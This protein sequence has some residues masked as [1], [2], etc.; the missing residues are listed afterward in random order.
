MANLRDEA[1]LA[2]KTTGHPLYKNERQALIQI[3]KTWPGN[4]GVNFKTTSSENIYLLIM[5]SLGSARVSRAGER[6]SRSRTSR[7]D[8][9]LP[10]SLFGRKS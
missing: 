5:D 9:F 4:R 2:R 6:V 10:A 8:S 7:P 1:E 3:A